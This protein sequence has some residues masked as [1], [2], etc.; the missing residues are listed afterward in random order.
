M[1][2]KKGT[3][4][5]AKKKTEEVADNQLPQNIVEFGEHVQENKKIYISQ[6]V[7]KE[8]HRF[9]K[10][11]KTDESG[12]VLLGNVVE[13]FGKTYIVI[14]AFTEA[15]Y[16]D[17]TPTTLKFTHETWEYIHKEINK[18][19]P[20]Y[21]I[22]GWIHTHPDFGIFLSDYDMFIQENFFQDENQIAYVVDPIQKIEGFYFWKDGK[23]EPCK[24]FYVY[25]KT[26]VKITVSPGEEKS[27]EKKEST[28][29]TEES[30]KL[31]KL[32]VLGMFGLILILLFFCFSL[33]SRITALQNQMEMLVDSANSSLSTIYGLTNDVATKVDD[34]EN[35][36]TQLEEPDDTQVVEETPF[37]DAA[38]DEVPNEI[39]PES[40]GV[41]VNG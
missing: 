18:N 17:A 28:A 20:D 25:D 11:K 9:T 34:L 26:G 30:S 39:T 1:A 5:S 8:I 6:N 27:K 38:V 31:R 16:C 3:S 23:V 4:T 29:V 14:K 10:D 21:K 15:K 22:V 12:G 36:V 40:E 19:Y 33:S 2:K 32:I 35:R 24:N 13:E 41:E 7:Y 37:I